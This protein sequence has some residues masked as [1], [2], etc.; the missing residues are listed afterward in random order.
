M[1]KTSATARIVLRTS[2][3]WSAGLTGLAALG[4]FAGFPTVASAFS[5]PT[6]EVGIVQRLGSDPELTELDFAAPVGTLLTLEFTD[7]S[8]QLQRQRMDSVTIAIR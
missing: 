4:V 1:V 3:L 5:N 8:G 2:R 7:D 6:L